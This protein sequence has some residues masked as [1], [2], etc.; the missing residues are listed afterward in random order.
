MDI[1]Q[2]S[3]RLH[4]PMPHLGG[5]SIQRKLQVGQIP[6]PPLWYIQLQLQQQ[7]GR[8]ALRAAAAGG[9]AGGCR[10]RALEQSRRRPRPAAVQAPAP[11]A[12]IVCRPAQQLQHA[13]GQAGW[14]WS[15]TEQPAGTKQRPLKARQH[16]SG[17]P[18]PL[19]LDT[20]SWGMNA[21]ITRFFSARLE[22]SAL[23][24]SP[25]IHWGCQQMLLCPLGS[26]RC[27]GSTWKRT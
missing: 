8:P 7:A 5:Y 19:A 22:C 17:L 6:C 20:S 13:D 10:G 1:V 16:P 9:A 24:H 4:L 14:L 11:L 26:T 23:R 15:A 21:S 27:T 18:P 3:S 25:G 12:G 2:Q